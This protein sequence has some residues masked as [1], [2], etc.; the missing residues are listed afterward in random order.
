MIDHHELSINLVVSEFSR[1]LDRFVDYL[2]QMPHVRIDRANGLSQPMDSCDVVITL[3]GR[4]CQQCESLLSPFVRN[5]G[6]VA[7]PKPSE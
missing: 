6:G 5:G 7:R 2:R 1:E 4:D 3:G